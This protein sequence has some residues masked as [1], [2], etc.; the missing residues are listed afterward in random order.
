M[1]FQR[2]SEFAIS[3]CQPLKKKGRRRGRAGF[4]S[5]SPRNSFMPLLGVSWGSCL[6]RW[7]LPLA[8]VNAP[9]GL[10]GLANPP[11]P[12][13]A[14]ERLQRFC[15]R[16]AR[17]CPCPPGQSQPALP[18]LSVGASLGPA[19]RVCQ[20]R[21]RARAAS[22]SCRRPGN[23]ALQKQ[24]SSH[25]QATPAPGGGQIN[26]QNTPGRGRMVVEMSSHQLL[27]STCEQGL[28]KTRPPPRVLRCRRATRRCRERG[29]GAD[30]QRLATPAPVTPRCA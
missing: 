18:S 11:C 12:H 2:A 17:P 26:Q 24:A 23:G 15:L 4:V 27:C 14:E 25:P 13:C 3:L 28:W 22:L 19:S 5:L 30:A 16:A 6:T 8:G 10:P 29:R 9:P 21:G 20:T 1:S 7:L